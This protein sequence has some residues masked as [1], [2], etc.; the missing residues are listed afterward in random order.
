MNSRDLYRII[1][2]IILVIAV[3]MTIEGDYT[4]A[5]ALFVGLIPL[6]QDLKNS[7]DDEKQS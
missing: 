1:A 5:V 3:K 6:M 2:F 7:R 4:N